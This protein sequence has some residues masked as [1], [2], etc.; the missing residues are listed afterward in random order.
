MLDVTS[1]SSV[2]SHLWTVH[3]VK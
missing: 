1:S 3:T 2:W